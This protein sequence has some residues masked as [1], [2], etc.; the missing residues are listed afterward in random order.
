MAI[1]M[2]ARRENAILL[3]KMAFWTC[4]A[5][6]GNDYQ[7]SIQFRKTIERRRRR[8]RGRSL[9]IVLKSGLSVGRASS[10]RRETN[11]CKSSSAWQFWATQEEIEAAATE[12]LSTIFTILFHISLSV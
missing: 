9:P 5:C 10:G 6:D 2:R 1:V 4:C 12:K 3:A 7:F 8:R 11:N